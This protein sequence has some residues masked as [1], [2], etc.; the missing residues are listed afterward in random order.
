MQRPMNQP[1]KLK[2]K[3]YARFTLFP[4]RF[5]EFSSRACPFRGFRL[6]ILRS[7]TL[8]LVGGHFQMRAKI[9][10]HYRQNDVAFEEI[11]FRRDKRVELWPVW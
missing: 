5:L 1:T 8:G 6:F 11:M 7:S 9:H 10:C 3:S 2:T 4:F